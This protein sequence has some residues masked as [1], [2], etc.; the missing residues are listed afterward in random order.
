MVAKSLVVFGLSLQ[1]LT[2]SID[3]K[4]APHSHS[5]SGLIL[6][7]VTQDE[8]KG[9]WK[10][11]A[12]DHPSMCFHISSNLMRIT[13]N[14]YRDKPL[15]LYRTNRIR[16]KHYIQ[17]L[18]TTI[19]RFKSLDIQMPN[20]VSQ[21]LVFKAIKREFKKLSAKSLSD[22]YFF[23]KRI[24][25]S[26]NRWVFSL[27]ENAGKRTITEN[28]ALVLGK[29]SS[30]LGKHP[31]NSRFPKVMKRFHLFCLGIIQSVGVSSPYRRHSWSTSIP[32]YGPSIGTR[33]QKDSQGF[34]S[35]HR[36]KNN[37]SNY[38]LPPQ[39]TN[40]TPSK[41]QHCAHGNHDNQSCNQPNGFFCEDMRNGFI[42][43]CFGMCGPKCWCWHWVCE[44]CCLHKACFQHDACCQRFMSSYC[45]LPFLYGFDC[46]G[47][48]MGYPRCL[49]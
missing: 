9:C 3:A 49:L 31:I 19:V 36:Q 4:I 29:I 43:L 20:L 26:R 39:A 18:G 46:R 27:T 25:Q 12:H 22:L 24:P 38:I 37:S 2:S 11:I 47:G 45:L 1:L 32:T 17:V 30:S 33:K 14:L 40:N 15:A 7:K 41:G 16:D 48:Y 42:P 35:F 13:R 23:L 44:D 21:S 5:T 8:V 34:T 10:D 6:R 28:E